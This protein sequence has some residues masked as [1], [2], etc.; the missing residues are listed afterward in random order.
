MPLQHVLRIEHH[1]KPPTD[2]PRINL[3]GSVAWGFAFGDHADQDGLTLGR[4][5]VLGVGFAR[6]SSGVFAPRD[7]TVSSSL[8]GM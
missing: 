2:P 1:T 4:A 7:S 6:V 3:C 5:E 8:K